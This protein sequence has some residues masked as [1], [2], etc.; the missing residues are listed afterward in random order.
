MNSFISIG[1]NIFMH[2]SASVA[3]QSCLSIETAARGGAVF[4]AISLDVVVAYNMTLGFVLEES[5]FFGCFVLWSCSSQDKARFVSAGG[6]VAFVSALLPMQSPVVVSQCTF[7][8]C[9][10]IGTY[11][12]ASQNYSVSGGAMYVN[13]TMPFY[14]HSCQFESVNNTGVIVN[15]FFSSEVDGGGSALRL[16]NLVSVHINGCV[17][18]KLHNR[19]STG[20]NAVILVDRDIV[21]SLV[22]SRLMQVSDSFLGSD[23][24][25]MLLILPIDAPS[26][27]T[28]AFSNLQLV[29][30]NVSSFSAV[31]VASSALF[32][33]S[34]STLVCPSG[35]NV[36]VVNASTLSMSC[37]NCPVLNFSYISN[38][39]SLDVIQQLEQSSTSLAAL[40]SCHFSSTDG[41]PGCPYGIVFC[42]GTIKV[43]SGLWMFFKNMSTES[44]SSLSFALTSAAR[45]PAGFCG[46]SSSTKSGCAVPAPLD[47]LSIDNNTALCSNNRTGI[48]CSHCLSGFTATVDE[49]GCMSNQEC[50]N[51]LPWIWVAV[52]L[53]YLVYGLY[54]A[55][56]C[57]DPRSGIMSALLFFGQ[58]SQFALPRLP[59]SAATFSNTLTR[60]SHFDSL[61]SSYTDVCLGV[62]L[63]TFRLILVKLWGPISVLVFALFWVRV[64]KRYQRVAKSVRLE[65]QISY[66]GTLAQC[67]LLI[68]SSL[69][70]AVFK[71]V[72]C[73]EVDGIG[74]VVFLDGSR[75]CYDTAWIAL[76][77]GVAV[78]ALAPFLFA[79]LLL[80]KKLRPSAYFAVC[81]AYTDRVYYWGAIT[82][83][84][85][86]FMSLAFA[87]AQ[88]PSLGQSSLLLISVLMTLLLIHFKP[89]VQL[90]TYRV[91]LLCHVCLIVQFVLS[92]IVHENESVGVSLAATGWHTCISRVSF[93]QLLSAFL[94][95]S[96]KAL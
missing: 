14:V 43:T 37:G 10:S 4:F 79:Y 76:A 80:Y 67:L 95:G 45:C 90:A 51:R 81:N 77:C 24:S 48:L 27:D 8:D 9:S 33:S 15:A 35:S 42:T 36:F 52:L 6:A 93:G 64:L 68:F 21:N 92:V 91:D 30:S 50:I 89:Y 7:I 3:L 12:I 18:Q 83:A 86:M 2:C 29:A 85:R 1:K 20:G 46:C 32:L 65:R 23:D 44:D 11:F 25:V 87:F 69:A 53:S 55:L 88:D 47:F 96:F 56:S 28:L 73:M 22:V 62:D 31:S 39:L 63:S 71:L 5:T 16:V 26:S 49:T 82:L 41:V 57:L 84:S 60:A 66:F 72:Q 19:S 13:G 54:V 75:M 70:A 78:L 61:V 94:Q 17:F 38:V 58:M 74:N 40:S 59:G 34:N